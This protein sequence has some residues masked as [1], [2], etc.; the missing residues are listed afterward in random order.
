MF[1]VQTSGKTN[2]PRIR[3]MTVCILLYVNDIN[4]TRFTGFEDL[5]NRQVIHSYYCCVKR[6][7]SLQFLNL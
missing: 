3:S 7:V 4:N 2:S 1:T 6:F 5:C